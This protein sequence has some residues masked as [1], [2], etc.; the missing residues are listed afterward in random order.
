MI[1]HRHP[2]AA[3]AGYAQLQS[4]DAFPPCWLGEITVH[5]RHHVFW[6][7]TG[8]AQAGVNGVRF[9][10]G[11]GQAIWFPAG[12]T[13]TSIETTPGTVATSALVPPD[14]LICQPTWLTVVDLS[15]SDT[16]VLARQFTRWRMP[17]L[18]NTTSA[19]PVEA[20]DVS[21]PD[22]PPIPR[23]RLLR[24]LAETVLQNPGDDT[25]LEGWAARLGLCTRQLTRR[26]QAETGM[27]YR[28]WRT[29][30]RVDRASHLLRHGDSVTRSATAVGF[31]TVPAFVRAFDRRFGVTP[32]VWAARVC[33]PVPASAT[34]TDHR[35]V[36]DCLGGLPAI[37]TMPRINR[38]HILIWLS[39]GTGRLDLGDKQIPLT[40]GDTTW[41]P[42]GVWHVIH[43]DEGGVFIP[44]GELPGTVPM[45]RHHMTV[46]R[47][48]KE[49]EPNLMY[50]AGLCYTH[51]LP[52][53][54]DRNDP[55]NM[56]DLLPPGVTPFARPDAAV[57]AIL[58]ADLA[59]G[60]R[61]LTQWSEKLGIPLGR[62]SERFRKETGQ[63]FTLWQTDLRMNSARYR[64]SEP[65]I[66]ISQI[67]AEVGY[68][69]VSGFTRAF[70]A[71]HG[72]TPTE[73]RKQYAQPII[74][75]EVTG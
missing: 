3:G 36:T 19:S 9:T 39:T 13:V 11:A 23:S 40:A 52:W 33:R 54:H 41:I 37:H 38:F 42:A 69:H 62:L 51:L 45:R 67:A 75:E 61:T 58:N 73:F 14:R 74:Y 7:T 30:V 1:A 72:M 5:S 2:T 31:A 46:T 4:R 18:T 27:S 57:N 22:S 6:V 60:P 12:A 50:R 47:I 26:F 53:P 64:L 25:S 28:N 21:A 29:L 63:T 70:S 8:K 71:R 49:L 20:T 66:P 43:L 10:L 68:P 34:T 15:A 48:T 32:G 56:T 24:D 17:F 65:G 16:D 55:A 44:V 59:T 35:V